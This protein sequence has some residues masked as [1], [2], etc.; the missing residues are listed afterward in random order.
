MK[1]RNVS[2]NFSSE[3]GYN[4][5][6]LK[7]MKKIIFTILI[8]LSLNLYSQRLENGNLSENLRAELVEELFK[9]T[10]IKIGDTNIIVLNFFIKPETPP[11][12]SCIDYY[13][14]DYSYKRYLKKSKN[15]SQ[16]FITEKMYDFKKK[17]VIED[18][19][20]EIEKLLFEN[21]KLCGNYIIILPNGKYVRKYGE[22]RQD[23]IPKLIPKSE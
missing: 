1:P 6:L 13:T 7:N 21:A 2:D 22:Y 8:L 10:G 14:N 17:N 9:L 5:I 4:P 20:G 16:F 18:K 3:L 15:I 12:G 19:N 11:N 23:E